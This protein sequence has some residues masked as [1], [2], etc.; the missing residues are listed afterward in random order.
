MR[1]KAQSNGLEDE[2]SFVPRSLDG[3]WKKS[4]AGSVSAGRLTDAGRVIKVATQ[5][6]QLQL[7]LIRPTW[8]STEVR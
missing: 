7:A 4:L 6:R 1:R 2:E 5:G 8:L 3:G